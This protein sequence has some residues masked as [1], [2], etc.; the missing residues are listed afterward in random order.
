MLPTIIFGKKICRSSQRA[1]HEIQEQ[2]SNTEEL[3]TSNAELNTSIIII[4]HLSHFDILKAEL[5]DSPDLIKVL[6]M[7]KTTRAFKSSSEVQLVIKICSTT[8]NE[9][10]DLNR[11]NSDSD[12]VLQLFFLRNLFSFCRGNI[13]KVGG[14][15]KPLTLKV[16][17]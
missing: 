8:K 5:P 4:K 6:N 9:F 17:M 2:S 15:H 7:S 11:F 14:Y 12:V 3:S 16:M 1:Q 13:V 10:S